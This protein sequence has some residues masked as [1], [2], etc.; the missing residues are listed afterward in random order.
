MAT[1][2]QNDRSPAQL[3]GAPW[4]GLVSAT[5]HDGPDT[6]QELLLA[7]GLDHVVVRPHVERLDF[8]PLVRLTR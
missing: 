3:P 1:S 6:G 7:E 8:G 5:P 4:L 2:I